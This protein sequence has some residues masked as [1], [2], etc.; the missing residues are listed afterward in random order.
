MEPKTKGGRTIE[1]YPLSDFE[2][3]Y[4][5]ESFVYSYLNELAAKPETD[6]VILVKTNKIL[7]M[8]QTNDKEPPSI[9]LPKIRVEK[10]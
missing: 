10:K 9:D 3:P 2:G 1:T 7:N 5:D 6:K 4:E 8:K